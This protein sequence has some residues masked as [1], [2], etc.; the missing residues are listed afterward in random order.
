MT[1]NDNLESLDRRRLPAS[2]DR[3]RQTLQATRFSLERLRSLLG[4]WQQ[5]TT[6]GTY[7]DARDEILAELTTSQAYFKE[8]TAITA[9]G[10]ESTLAVSDWEI[11][12]RR[13][14]EELHRLHGKIRS[15]GIPRAV[16]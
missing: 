10:A 13:I 8:L 9:A 11:E 16:E 6:C 5:G 14:G 7:A 2:R 12:T 3:T 15:L 4:T 1:D